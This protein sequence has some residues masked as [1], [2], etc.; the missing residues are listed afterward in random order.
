[1]ANTTEGQ[2]LCVAPFLELSQ[3]PSQ[4]G[5]EMLLTTYCSSSRKSDAEQIYLDGS[6]LQLEVQSAV[7]LAPS[8]NG[9]TQTVCLL[10]P[11]T[12]HAVLILLD[13]LQDN[14]KSF[15][16]AKCC[17][18]GVHGITTYLIHRSSGRE[19]K[20][21]LSYRLLHHCSMHTSSRYAVNFRCGP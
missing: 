19:D 4:E 17:G 7:Y 21:A 15:E 6:V 12:I 8:Q 11:W 5:C 9:S 18:H 14:T 16:L 3:F 20:P 10:R 2:G 13:R 1:M